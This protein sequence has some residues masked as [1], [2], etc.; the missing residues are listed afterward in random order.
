[1]YLHCH[2]VKVSH[3][4][5]NHG[6]EL[7]FFLLFIEIAV[8]LGG[9]VTFPAGYSAGHLD[10]CVILSGWGLCVYGGDDLSAAG[11]FS[12]VT[13]V[14]LALVLWLPGWAWD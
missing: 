3:T 13:G 9:I 12:I 14:Q 10:C 11:L 7:P 1:M 4:G 2:A 8:W 5:L 6:G